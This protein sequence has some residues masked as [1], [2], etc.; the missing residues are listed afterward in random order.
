MRD[1]VVSDILVA[2]VC[3]VEEEMETAERDAIRA[4]PEVRVVPQIARFVRPTLTQGKVGVLHAGHP[5]I[6]K[7][8]DEKSYAALLLDQS[9]RT[10][11]HVKRGQSE[12]VRS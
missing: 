2:G 7:T 5:A 6:A 11:S 12:R 9:D 3:D 4:C 8:P 10:L 1:V